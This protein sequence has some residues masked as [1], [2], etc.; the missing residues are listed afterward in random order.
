[1]ENQNFV[2]FKPDLFTFFLKS[3][4]CRGATQ[5][6]QEVQAALVPSQEIVQNIAPHETTYSITVFAQIEQQDIHC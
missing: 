1:M 4:N 3:C 5:Q 6:Q 2:L